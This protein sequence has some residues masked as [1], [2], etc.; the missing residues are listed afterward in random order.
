MA[1]QKVRIE[2]SKK[3]N[4]QQRVE[5][6][7][8]VIEFIRER[9]ASGKD[10]NNRTFPQY[11]KKYAKKKGVSRK[12]VDLILTSEMLEELRGLTH[13]SGSITVG[14]EAG[15]DVNGKAEGNIKGTYGQK[16][17]IPGKKRDYLGITKKDLKEIE[18]IVLNE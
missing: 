17:P 10:K 1:Q 2:V 12:D 7:Q 14:Y 4:P 3:L 16:K 9:T 6:I 13:R 15:S 11:T 18:R 5:T 8:R